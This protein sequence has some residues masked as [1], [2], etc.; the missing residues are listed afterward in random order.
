[1][2]ATLIFG[3]DAVLARWAADRILHIEGFGPCTAIGIA[4][5][6]SLEAEMYA[7]VIF[8]DWIGPARTLQV[9]VASRNPRWCRKHVIQQLL[10]YP[11]HQLGINKL[12]SAIPHDNARSLRLNLGLGFREEGTLRHH[13]GPGRHAVVTSMLR[14]EWERSPWWTPREMRAAA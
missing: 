4:A 9:S 2:S 3:H 1:M 8:H 5:D 14:K 10:R 11:F 13:F 6:D 7:V 12:W